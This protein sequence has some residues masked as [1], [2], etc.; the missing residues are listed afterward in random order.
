MCSLRF[1][2]NLLIIEGVRFA[3]ISK[4]TPL[5]KLSFAFVRFRFA[6]VNC[7]NYFGS[8]VKPWCTSM[9]LNKYYY[10]YVSADN[11]KSKYELSKVSEPNE[12]TSL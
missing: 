5:P 12:I 8:I 11:V 7:V 6:S 1:E 3:S 2:N 10:V 4:K 9:N